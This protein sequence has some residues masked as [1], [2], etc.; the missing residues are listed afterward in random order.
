MKVRQQDQ[1][2]QTLILGNP[3][4]VRLKLVCQVMFWSLR[5]IAEGLILVVLVTKA[6]P[7]KF[8]KPTLD[9]W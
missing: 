2:L 9:Q 8:A 6:L 4:C 5:L 1:K 3:Q 7:Q